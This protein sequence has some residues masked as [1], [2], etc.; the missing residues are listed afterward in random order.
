MRFLHPM[1]TRPRRSGLLLVLGA[2]L[3]LALS[4]CGGDDNLLGPKGTSSV[5]L[6]LNGLE[7]LPDGLVYRG[8]VVGGEPDSYYGVPLITFN[9]G[10]EGVLVDPEADT[11][12]AGPFRV[13]VHPDEILAIGVS[14]ELSSQLSAYSSFTFL[15]GGDLVGGSAALSVENW[16][17]MGASMAD[18][19]GRFILSTPTDVNPENE[20]SGIWFM[21]SSG[22]SPA[23]G[24]SL[25]EAPTGWLYE[26]WATVDGQP[27]STGKFV[28]PDGE[29]GGNPYS[30]PTNAPPFP[31]EDFLS[32]APAGVTFPTDLS[33]GTVFVTLEPWDTWDVEPAD[34]FFLRVLEGQVPAGAEA[35]VPYPM[36]NLAQGLPSGSATVQAWSAA[37]GG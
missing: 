2:S 35:D 21:D 30:G 7:P 28:S 15:L 18:A 14:L 31:G 25:P 6:T 3:V 5:N 11:V 32:D 26:G 36:A 16:L 4:G 8:W 13:E 34:P 10:P 29:D 20:L 9:V 23:P 37:P 19:Q 12:L 22:S 33:G 17:A 27:V 24:L 1:L